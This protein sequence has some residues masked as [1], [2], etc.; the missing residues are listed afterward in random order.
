MRR[1]SLLAG[2]ALLAAIWAGPLLA[3]WRESF[4]AHMLAH[5]GV[6]ALAAP[7]IAIG[8][9]GFPFARLGQRAGQSG[10]LQSNRG[11]F[12][13][14]S[15]RQEEATFAPLP[16]AL[17]ILASLVELIVVWLWHAPAMRALAASSTAATVFEQ[18]S[19]LAVG[20]LLWLACLAPNTRDKS[21]R[22]AAGG[23]GLLLTS[24]HMT[25][26]GAL[27]A[28]S[29]RPL[30]A[31]GEVT[32]F[33]IVLDAQQDQDLGGVIMLLIGGAVYLAG[34]LALFARLLGDGPARKA[35]R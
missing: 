25:L 10:G 19:F 28:L 14:R 8:L 23:F 11:V 34:G 5:M 12:N 35:A 13:A 29:P 2:L 18:M 9:M 6:V 1:F 17:P 15:L 24:V 20:L 30:Y 22:N 33:G 27:L 7:L 31:T 21:A 3:A 26:L 32:C 16:I 4:A